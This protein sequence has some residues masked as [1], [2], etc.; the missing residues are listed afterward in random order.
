MGL[1][2]HGLL[3]YP[4]PVGLYRA[5]LHRPLPGHITSGN[6][7]DDPYSRWFGPVAEA[8]ASA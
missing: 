7:G 2:E 1:G 4:S 3:G 5:R 8:Q 6:A